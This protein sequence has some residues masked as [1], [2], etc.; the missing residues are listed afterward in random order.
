MSALCFHALLLPI[1]D[2][3]PGFLVNTTG[4]EQLYW[5]ADLSFF[6]GISLCGGVA[7]LLVTRNENPSWYL[8][9]PLCIMF[10]ITA[11][12]P[13]VSG[14]LVVHDPS[15]PI[16]H[17]GVLWILLSQAAVCLIP[18]C[19]ALFFWSLR[20][21]GRWVPVLAAL[22]LLITINSA[23]M[24]YAEFSPWLVSAGLIPPEPPSMVDGQVV[25]TENDGPL[26]LYLGFGLPVIGI[27][28]LILAA[29]TWYTSLRTPPS[30]SPFAEI[31]P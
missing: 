12:S 13:L 15:P 30:D 3:V 31:Q 26:I 10:A 23:A 14:I 11:V 1:W 16:Y 22:A 17:P 18:P 20:A 27:F 29:A 24:L 2:T 9:V 5:L 7:F 21:L 19:T 4:L 8:G 28:F 25:R 6:A